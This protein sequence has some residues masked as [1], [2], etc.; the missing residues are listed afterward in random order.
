MIFCGVVV[1]GRG[2]GGGGGRSKFFPRGRRIYAFDLWN[3]SEEY[4]TV[5]LPLTIG[6]KRES[7][8]LVCRGEGQ[9]EVWLLNEMALNCVAWQIHME[10]FV[11]ETCGSNFP[12][13][14]WF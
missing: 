14:V 3:I 4:R 2:F 12:P 6:G 11:R 5:S 9:G 7:T 1:Q 8:Y 13:A 10:Q